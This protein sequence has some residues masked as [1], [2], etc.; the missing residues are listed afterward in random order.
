MSSYQLIT[1]TEK[2]KDSMS[3]IKC[4]WPRGGF[5]PSNLCLSS[6][7][8]PRCATLQPGQESPRKP[9]W[10]RSGA[11][12]ANTNVLTAV[13]SVL[14]CWQRSNREATLISLW[15]SGQKTLTR[16]QNPLPDCAVCL[17]QH[18]ETPH[19][20]PSRNYDSYLAGEAHG[21][22]VAVTTLS[23]A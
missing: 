4:L 9:I 11:D 1:E 10:I 7:L 14:R 5:G 17:Y 13:P 12:Q 3:L 21:K 16:N 2:P 18:L 19:L 15:T 8:S 22:S 23:L 6:H 20:H